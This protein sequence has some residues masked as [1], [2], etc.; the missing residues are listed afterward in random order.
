M[1]MRAVSAV[2]KKQ[3]KDTLKNKE[4][5][6]QFFLFPVMA[7]IMQNAIK[8][9]GMP[10]N[11]FVV[12]FATMYVGMA[13]L[14]AMAAIL[15]EEKE[16]NTLRV[17]LMSNVKAAEYLAGTGVYVLAVCMLGALVF[18]VVGK[19][20]GGELAMFLL[21]MCIGILSSLLIGAAIGVWSRSQMGATSMTVP[22]MLVFAFLPMIAM[23]NSGIAKVSRFTYSQ[24]ISN[25]MTDIGA[26]AMS[27]ESI[28]I[29]AMNMAA[30]MAVFWVA[31]KRCGLE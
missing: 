8:V 10:E 14:T 26:E 31:Y 21:I 4:V 2:W 3:V 18:G 11:F 25:M 7:I 5:L 28:V 17:L 23:F 16:K 20:R 13:P 9:P 30:A 15:A 1:K 6:I 24:Q 12:L 29:I 22:V 19:Y 27:M